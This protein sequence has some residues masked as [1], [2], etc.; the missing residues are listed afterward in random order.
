MD[1]SFSFWT[2]WSRKSTCSFLIICMASTPKRI[3]VTVSKHWNPSIDRIRFF[4]KQWSCS[5]MLFRYFCYLSRISPGML[6]SF[7]NCYK[8]SWIFIDCYNTR[9]WNMKRL[10]DLLEKAFCNLQVSCFAQVKSIVFPFEST[11]RY[12][13]IHWP[14]IFIN[15]SSSLQESLVCLRWRQIH[16]SNS[17]PYWWTQRIIVVWEMDKP[18]SSIISTTSRKLRLY[19]RYHLTVNKTIRLIML[20]FEYIFFFYTNHASS[21]D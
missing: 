10:Q 13:Y 6:F 12:R 11:A 18:R 3:D 19:R 2:D 1:N 20:P 4:I 5:T 17:G 14:F 8:I 9:F 16:L 7:F 21:L 15:V